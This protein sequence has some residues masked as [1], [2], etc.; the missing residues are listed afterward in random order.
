MKPFSLLAASSC[1]A[2]LVSCAGVQTS[3]IL[4]RTTPAGA[5]LYVNDSYAGTTPVRVEVPK[6]KDAGIVA[7][8]SGYKTIYRKLTPEKTVGGTIVWGLR[9]ERS[10]SFRNGESFTIKLEPIDG[11]GNAPPWLPPP[12]SKKPDFR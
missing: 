9:D 3:T 5:A 11:A 4:I 8:K 2:F 12:L 10:G 1:A 6:H 7:R